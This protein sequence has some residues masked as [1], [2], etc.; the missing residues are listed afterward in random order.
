MKVVGPKTV[1]A[2][3]SEFG[4]KTHTSPVLTGSS[5][6]CASAQR[7]YHTAQK[8]TAGRS[9]ASITFLETEPEWLRP[10][11]HAPTPPDLAFRRC[12]LACCSSAFYPSGCLSVSACAAVQP[13]LCSSRPHVYSAG[14]ASGCARCLW[15]PVTLAIEVTDTALWPSVEAGHLMHAATLE[16]ET[17][18]VPFLWPRKQLCTTLVSDRELSAT[19]RF[20]C[21]TAWSLGRCSLLV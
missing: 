2:R 3:S 12:Q 17:F 10:H 21:R 14:G 7:Q 20:V 15:R 4:W 1:V 11:E 19:A 13:S 8:A 6:V 16:S 5:R 9:V 18:P